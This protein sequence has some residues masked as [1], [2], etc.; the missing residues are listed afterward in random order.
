MASPKISVFCLVY[1]TGKYVL[2]TLTSIKQQTFLDFELMIV[3]DFSSDDSVALIAE[4]IAEN[5]SFFQFPVQFIKHTENKG[6][7]KT[8]NELLGIAK[9]SYFAL[10][11]DDYWQASFLEKTYNVITGSR[12]HIAYVYADTAI[13]DYNTKEYWKEDINPLRLFSQFCKPRENEIEKIGEN[14]YLFKKTLVHSS[15]IEFNPI[16]AF[17][18]L[19]KKDIVIESGGYD[20]NYFF[21]D[22]PMWLKLSRKYDCLFLDEK[23]ATYNR[24]GANMTSSKNPHYHISILN[25]LMAE[26]KSGN[27]QKSN[28]LLKN[29]IFIELKNACL[30]MKNSKHNKSALYALLLKLIVLYPKNAVGLIKILIN[31]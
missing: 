19:V 15:L 20:E 25:I 2:E 16:I 3:D 28:A 7:P 11:G 8:L 27:F 13:M 26:I 29:R 12:E 17:T 23:L 30:G 22:M 14:L 4:W 18:V 21:E 9:G 6:I 10:I 24:H 1:N 31:N 5:D